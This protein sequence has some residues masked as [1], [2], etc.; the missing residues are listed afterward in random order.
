MMHS[1]RE[2]L[3]KQH[4]SI[5]PGLS[6][7]ILPQRPG[8][9]DITPSTRHRI[10]AGI[11]LAQFVSVNIKI[12]ASLWFSLFFEGIKSFVKY[13]FFEPHSA[14]RARNQ[15]LWFPQVGCLYLKKHR[16]T[17]NRLPCFSQQCFPQFPPTLTNQTKLVGSARRKYHKSPI[18]CAESLNRI[19]NR[20]LLATCTFTPLYGRLCNAMGRR[21]A[22]HSAV[23]FAAV[24]ILACGLSNSMKMLIFSR[25][26][27]ILIA[28]PT[29]FSC[30]IPPG[31]WFRCRWDLHN[32]GVRDFMLDL[33]RLTS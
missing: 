8:P 3:L 33:W 10:L 31:V 25:F 27:R 22:H 1:E 17:L 32:V 12:V 19:M 9:L 2:P 28:Q 16:Q 4:G 6:N 18:I 15:W 21:G 5:R 20:Y 11:W 26:V 7:Y 13:N 14:N 30:K 23:F 29:C 24:G